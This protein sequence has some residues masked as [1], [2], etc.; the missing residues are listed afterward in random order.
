MTMETILDKLKNLGITSGD[1]DINEGERTEMMNQ[2]A[3]YANAFI[4]EL[5]QVKG[6]RKNKVGDLTIKNKK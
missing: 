5:R 3:G 1:L 4:S 2:V 6:F